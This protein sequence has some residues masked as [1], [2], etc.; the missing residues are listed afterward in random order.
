MKQYIKGNKILTV[1]NIE[2]NYVKFDFFN[3]KVMTHYF[4]PV[5]EYNNFLTYLLDV[6]FNI[7]C[8]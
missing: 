4:K 5:A 3:G 2:M 8:A 1:N 7:K 6:W